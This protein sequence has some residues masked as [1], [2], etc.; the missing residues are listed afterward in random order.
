MPCLGRT[1]PGRA[2]QIIGLNGIDVY[3]AESVNG[4]IQEK[5][6]TRDRRVTPTIALLLNKPNNKVIGAV[7]I[8]ILCATSGMR[9]TTT[10]ETQRTQRLHREIHRSVFNFRN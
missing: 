2:A 1:I 6:T 5:L 9:D 4:L 10:I 8:W 3:G 7:L